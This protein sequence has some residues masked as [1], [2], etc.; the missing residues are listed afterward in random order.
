MS[1]TIAS[2]GQFKLPPNR[3]TA[4]IEIFA[5]TGNLSKTHKIG[6]GANLQMEMRNPKNPAGFLLYSGYNYCLGKKNVKSFVGF[7]A[8]VGVK[9]HLGNFIS[10]GGMTGITFI[11]GGR[12]LRYTYSTFL[13]FENEDWFTDIKFTGFT[14]PGH[15]NDYSGF[16][17]RFAYRL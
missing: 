9:Y 10:T 8:L 4:G 3:S 2:L 1:V 17:V 12:G 14:F 6:L 11:N 15:E 13:G 7:P 5:P 16:S